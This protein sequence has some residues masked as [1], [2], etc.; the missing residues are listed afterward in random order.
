LLR[1]TGPLEVAAG[2]LLLVV[3]AADL[4]PEL[5]PPQTASHKAIPAP[6]DVVMNPRRVVRFWSPD[7][8]ALLVPAAGFCKKL[9]LTTIQFV[10]WGV[11]RLTH[12]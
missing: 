1:V 2:A 5:E 8:S 9:D 10:F 3:P 6:V 11:K 12:S 4:E 7:M